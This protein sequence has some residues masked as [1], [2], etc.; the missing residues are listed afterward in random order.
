[1]RR[2]ISPVLGRAEPA[3]HHAR[4]CIDLTESNP[5]R[6]D[7]DLAAAHEAMARAQLVAGDRITASGWQAR[8]RAALAAVA[9]PEDRAQI[10]ADLDSLSI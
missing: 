7:W 9:D 8:A 1:M 3:L 5:D 10:E 2:T 4:R 6:E